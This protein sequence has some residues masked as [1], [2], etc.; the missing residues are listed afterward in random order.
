MS[1][2]ETIRRIRELL[3]G[4]GDGVVIG[5]GD[6]CAALSGIGPD[7]LLV[8]V[9]ALV[10]DRH[11]VR[12]SMTPS[13]V[14]RKLAAV[15]LSDIA[16]MGG[17]PRWAVLSLVVPEAL[18]ATWPERLTTGVARELADFGAALVG[19]NL[20]GLPGPT[21]GLVADLTLIGEVE[22]DRVLRRTGARP[23]DRVC[24][25]GA[26]GRAG[27]GRLLLDGR[28]RLPAELHG[29]L[30][31]AFRRPTPR[32][33]EGRVLGSSGAVTSAIDLSDGLA[34]DAR[35]LAE[36]GGHDLALRLDLLPVP[37]AVRAVVGGTSVDA[38][39]FAA[40]AGED[41]ELLF[42]VDA[43]RASEVADL[44]RDRTGTAVTDIGS[45]EKRRTAG[46]EVRWSGAD[47][48]PVAAPPPGF[49]HFTRSRP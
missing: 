22:V 17:R 7:L 48:R 2:F 21:A 36:A 18:E 43:G 23:G 6:D 39:R 15:N 32:V 47:G 46:P 11:F 24:V 1:E 12:A 4:V 49:D 38:G 41:Y 42:T 28:L 34:S 19:G 10:E 44:V 8:T 9:D 13:A 25:T 33:R 26:L 5:P 16:A 45:V 29:D 31:A 20:A 14:G 3:P 40:S 27:A 35:H 30:L 37:D